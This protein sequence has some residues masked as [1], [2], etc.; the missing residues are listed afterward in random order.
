MSEGSRGSPGCRQA[1]WVPQ[2]QEVVLSVTVCQSRRPLDSSCCY[3]YTGRRR[4]Q[5]VPRNDAR[6]WHTFHGKIA[7]TE[8]I[9]FALR[10]RRAKSSL[11]CDEIPKGSRALCLVVRNFP[12]HQN[13]TSFFPGRTILNPAGTQNFRQIREGRVFKCV[14]TDS[15]FLHAIPLRNSSKLTI[16]DSYGGVV[17]LIKGLVKAH[18]CGKFPGVPSLGE[19]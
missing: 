5:P 19:Q 12:V 16:A 9:S 7:A 1:A 15:A 4:R 2:A 8:F 17:V 6:R 10:S 14:G 11:C 13:T 3:R 18:V